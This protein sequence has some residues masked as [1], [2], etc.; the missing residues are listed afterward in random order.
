[1]SRVSFDTCVRRSFTGECT[2]ELGDLIY[3]ILR[4]VY[5]HQPFIFINDQPPD[6]S[7]LYNDNYIIPGESNSYEEISEDDNEKNNE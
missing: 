4:H 6:K 3:D 1:M 5:P 7:V 2:K